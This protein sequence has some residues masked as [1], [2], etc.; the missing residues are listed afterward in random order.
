ME[1]EKLKKLQRE[2]YN[3]LQEADRVLKKYK[4]KKI[5]VTLTI[6]TLVVA[7]IK[8]FFGTIEIYNPFGYP[9][10]SSKFYKVSVNN[11][12]TN[13]HYTVKHTIPLIP[14]LV[15][16]DSYYM[17]NSDVR[18]DLENDKLNIKE[19]NKVII[20]IEEYKCFSKD[21]HRIECKNIH[22]KM[23]KTN[24]E[25]IKSMVITKISNPHGEVY[26]GKYMKD[27]SKYVKD[28]GIYHIQIVVGHSLTRT[29]VYFYIQI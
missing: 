15:H 20:G 27:I 21:M 23:E 28:K 7:F 19:P 25:K 6:I 22:Q 8:I 11:E 3:D 29:K 17:G 10:T 5:I 14:F 4:K 18:D 24:E 12:L 26:N 1:N 9:S 16:F 13:S 2:A